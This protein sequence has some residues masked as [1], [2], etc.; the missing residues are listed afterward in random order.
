MDGY[1]VLVVG[2]DGHGV[3]LE[4]AVAVCSVACHGAPDFVRVLE[5]ASERVLTGD[6]SRDI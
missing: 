2:E 4:G 6:M 5:V 1:S 3:E